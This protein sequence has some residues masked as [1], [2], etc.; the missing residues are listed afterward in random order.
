MAKKQ[1]VPDTTQKQF[2]KIQF[3][4]RQPVFFTWLGKICYHLIQYS[5]VCYSSW[6]CNMHSNAFVSTRLDKCFP[7]VVEGSLLRSPIIIIL[8]L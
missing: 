2:N 7:R 5:G 8:E 1:L 4:Q 3:K 6:L